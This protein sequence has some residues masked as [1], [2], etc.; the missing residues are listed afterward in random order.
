MTDGEFHKWQLPTILKLL[1]TR[2]VLMLHIPRP[3]ILFIIISGFQIPDSRASFKTRDFR[4]S[5]LLHTVGVV[6]AAERAAFLRES[7][8][9]TG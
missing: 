6:D 3:P 2:G 4:P 9:L 1:K 7:A 5:D 8:R